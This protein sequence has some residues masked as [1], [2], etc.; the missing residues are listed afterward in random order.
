[1]TKNDNKDDA[2]LQKMRESLDSIDKKLEVKTPD[3]AYFR[4]MVADGAEKKQKHKRKETLVFVAAAVSILTLEIYTFN[5][6]M[7]FFAIVQGVA[8]LS[9]PALLFILFRQRNRQGGVR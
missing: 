3:M 1:M 4:K 6:S 8:L 7:I 9:L 2:I 5:L